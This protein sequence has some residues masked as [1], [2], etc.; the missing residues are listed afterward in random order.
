MVVSVQVIF[1]TKL[2]KYVFW[3]LKVTS[4]IGDTAPVDGERS[5]KFSGN[6]SSQIS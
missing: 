2:N 6:N 1:L 3:P 4:Q 5:Q